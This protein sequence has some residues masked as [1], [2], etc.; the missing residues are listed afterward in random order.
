M[1]HSH[2]ALLIEGV[3]ILLGSEIIVGQV[4][5]AHKALVYF[6][7]G[8]ASLYG[9]VH[10]T[11]NV[12]SLLPLSQSVVHWGPSWAHSAFMFQDFNEYLITQV[13]S[14]NALHNKYANTN[15]VGQ[16]SI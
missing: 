16:K 14:S 10:I 3:S 13:K 5:Y 15:T 6:V 2:W 8:V 1:Y 9:E 7:G 4:D 11:F 12:H